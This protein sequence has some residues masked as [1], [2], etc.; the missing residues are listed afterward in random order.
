MLGMLQLSA[1]AAGGALGA[2]ARFALSNGVYRL[3]GRDFPWGTLAVNL[4][5]SLLMGVL[6][7]LFL[8][9]SLVSA[10]WRAAI[11]IGFLG[12]FTTFSTFSLETLTLVEQGE[13]LRAFLNVGASL[14]LCLGACW[15][16]MVAARAL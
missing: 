16:G 7:V 4:S 5:G 9:R 15:L 14:L 3:L 2:V 6:F 8:E 13:V 1:I 12:A 10:E 11:L